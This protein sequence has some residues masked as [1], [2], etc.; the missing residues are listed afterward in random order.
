VEVAIIEARYPYK[1]SYLDEWIEAW[2][3]HADFAQVF[4]IFKDSEIKALGKSLFRFDL[5]V[6]LH[7]VTADSNKWLSDLSETLSNRSCPIILFVGNEYSNPW[8]SIEARLQNIE[9]IAPEIIATQLP[10]KSGDFL[11]AGLGSK[12]VETPHALPLKR[13]S[14]FEQVKRKIDLGFRGFDYPW[15]LLDSDRNKILKEVSDLYSSQNLSVDVSTTERLDRNDWYRFL[16]ISKTTV[17]SEGGSNYIF[18]NDEVWFEALKYIDSLSSRKLLANDFP[19]VKILR[20]LPVGIK[21]NLRVIGKFLGKE[22]GATSVLPPAILEEVLTR[23]NVEDYQFISG[24]ALTSRHLDA[25]FCGTW[26][27]LTPGDYNGV[28][29]PG[30]HYSVWDSSNP[31]SVLDEVEHAV[32]SN[33]SAYIYD[34]LI[35]VN[36]HQSRINKLLGR[37][38]S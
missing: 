17:A 27:I 14:D 16:K 19:G 35:Q 13:V 20:S 2:K 23:I 36:S 9:R 32:H 6:I 21:N 1:M 24:K 30:V 29:R 34:E 37:L 11:Y 18:R 38:Y 4:N 22:Q 31:T 26:Q 25:I 12:V 33:K 8:L 15:F 5:I 10:Q 3:S 28:L 7:S